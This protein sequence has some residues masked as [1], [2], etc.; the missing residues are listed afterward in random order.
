MDRIE[1]KDQFMKIVVPSPYIT[2]EYLSDFCEVQNL[3]TINIPFPTVDK[4]ILWTTL[5]ERSGWKIQQNNL[6]Q[7]VRILDVNHVRR[8]WVTKEEQIFS[9]LIE[10]VLSQKKMDRVVSRKYGIVLCGGGTRGAYQLG[11]WKRMQELGIADKITGFSGASVGALN[12]LLFAQGDYQA[13]KDAWYSMEQKDFRP[14][15]EMIKKIL[16]VLGSTCIAPYST[17]PEVAALLNKDSWKS[18]AVLDRGKL[19]ETIDRYISWKKIQSKENLLFVSLTAFSLPHI[20]KDTAK[21]MGVFLQSEYPSL[22]GISFQEIKDKVLASASY[23]VAYPLGKINKR[24]YIDGGFLDNSPARPL[25]EAGYQRIFVVH[26][27]ECMSKDGRKE[28]ESMEKNLSSQV[29]KSRN[30]IHI[31]PSKNLGSIFDINSEQTRARIQL[32]YDDAVKMLDRQWT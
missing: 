12:M 31:W 29:L 10:Y 25:V 26:L 18:L 3:R 5:L 21:L 22:A 30:I 2:A 7:I 24:Y 13:A 14:S 27:S 20:P 9:P 32:G 1:L 6:T 15:W 23:P 16:K 11:V 19:E 17:I 4:E 8:A 28:Y